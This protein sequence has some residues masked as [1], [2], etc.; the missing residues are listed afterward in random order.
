MTKNNYFSKASQE[1]SIQKRQGIQ[2][3][4][5]QI[6]EPTENPEN[7]EHLKERLAKIDML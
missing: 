1:I 5:N 6:E 7:I 2:P 4:W 3:A